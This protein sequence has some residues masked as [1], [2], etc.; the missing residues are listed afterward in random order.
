MERRVPDLDVE[1]EQLIEQL[2]G[3]EGS[4]RQAPAPPASSGHT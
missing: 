4:Q 3:S 1:G 2:E